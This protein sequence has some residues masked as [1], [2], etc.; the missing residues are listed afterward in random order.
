MFAVILLYRVCSLTSWICRLFYATLSIAVF[1]CH[2]CFSAAIF[3]F[4]TILS[5]LIAF[6]T[7]IIPVYASLF[8]LLFLEKYFSALTRFDFWNLTKTFYTSSFHKL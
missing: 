8:D 6:F 3:G 2:A 7:A 5:F 1:T 4:S